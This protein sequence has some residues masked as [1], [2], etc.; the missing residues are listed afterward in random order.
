[1]R[2]VGSVV[3]IELDI[4]V[5]GSMTVHD[6]HLICTQIEESIRE[7]L[8]NVL[9]VTIH[10]DPAGEEH[11]KAEGRFGITRSLLDEIALAYFH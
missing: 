5:D 9:D 11:P 10:V 1:M 7:K 2:T 4:L 3:A 8:D 6:S